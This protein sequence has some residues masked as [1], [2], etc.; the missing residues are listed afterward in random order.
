MAPPY[1]LI[2]ALI[3]RLGL[4]LIFTVT[5]VI[6]LTCI[7]KSLYGV[8]IMG[9]ALGDASRNFAGNIGPGQGSRLQAR[10]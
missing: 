3:L 9:R 1:A 4:S 8:S 2:L 6:N 5:D 10:I 7:L